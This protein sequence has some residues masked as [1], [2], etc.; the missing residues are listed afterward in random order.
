MWRE[1]KI[2]ERVARKRKRF[3]LKASIYFAIVLASAIL[4]LLTDGTTAVFIATLFL[5]LFSYSLIKLVIR[6]EVKVLF[7][8]AKRGI[9]IKEHEFCMRTREPYSRYFGFY[10]TKNAWRAYR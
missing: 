2:K 3:F 1:D 9:N 5:I 4:L 7:S 8:S 10:K 6:S